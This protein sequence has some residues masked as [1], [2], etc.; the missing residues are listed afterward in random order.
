M[1]FNP[2][3]EYNS[4]VNAIDDLVDTNVSKYTL[5]QKAR[6]VNSGLDKAYSIL[7]NSVDTKNYDDHNF[8][9]LPQ[10]TYDITIGERN[11]TVY[12]DQEGAEI[13]KI[14]KVFARDS[15]GNAY[16]LISKDIRQH[17]AD[18]IA[19]GDDT[20]AIQAYDWV[21]TSMVFDVTP[22]ATIL[23][24]L[25]IFY[26]RNSSYFTEADTTKEPGL[27]AIFHDY[28]VYYAS[29]KYAM[30]KG[31]QRKNDLKAELDALA[32]GLAKFASSQAVDK[33]TRLIP[34]INNVH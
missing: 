31:L 34:R 23:D 8:T 18:N 26:M 19:Y 29:W 6:A 27:P 21:G 17:N 4:M 20:G 24:G 22:E 33:N 16:E 3:T 2:A 13:L 7:F 12:K 10:G 14:H 32:I 11:L 1:Q 15:N 28:L 9:T 5:A 30:T 25:K